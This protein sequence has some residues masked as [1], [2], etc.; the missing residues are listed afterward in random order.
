MS[1]GDPEHTLVRVLSG[2]LSETFIGFFLQRNM[3]WSFRGG[4]RCP[5]R[6]GR[7]DCRRGLKK[8]LAKGPSQNSN[9]FVLDVRDP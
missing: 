8:A 1:V 6:R 3:T 5:F 2:T 4:W 9:E 7:L